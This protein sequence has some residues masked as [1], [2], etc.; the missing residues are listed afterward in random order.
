MGWRRRAG[1]YRLKRLR[2]GGVVHDDDAV[3]ATVVAARDGAEALLACRV[4][5]LQLDGLAVEL[6]GADF[7]RGR[8]ERAWLRILLW[9][10]PSR[11]GV[12]GWRVHCPA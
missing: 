7:L 6:D 2:V 3:S 10:R 1:T 5:N 9:V 11:R 8:W 4:P 12:A